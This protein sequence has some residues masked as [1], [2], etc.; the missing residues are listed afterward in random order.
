M[1]N[2]ENFSTVNSLRFEVGTMDIFNMIR[3]LAFQY[4]QLYNDTL[5][6]QDQ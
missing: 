4:S 3:R 5:L 1:A 2:R 6:E